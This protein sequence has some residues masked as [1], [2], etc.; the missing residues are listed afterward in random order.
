M[1][2]YVH[3]PTNL[4]CVFYKSMG[5]DDRDCMAYDIMHERSRYTYKIQGEVKQ[6]G[7]STQYTSPGRGNFNPHDGFKGQGGQGRG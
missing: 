3:K 6:E 5:H 7:N 2:K 4:Y 1:K